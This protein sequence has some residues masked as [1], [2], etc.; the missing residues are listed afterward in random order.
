MQDL[1]GLSL[2]FRI[3]KKAILLRL[4]YT[5]LLPNEM[6]WKFP[7]EKNLLELI[8][9]EENYTSQASGSK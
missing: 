3:F 8:W 6:K 4:F 1:T 7:D 9:L 2:V 5:L